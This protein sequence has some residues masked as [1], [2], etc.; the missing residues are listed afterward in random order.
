MR[1]SASTRVAASMRWPA[2]QRARLMHSWSTIVPAP[3]CITVE[4]NARGCADCIHVRTSSN[5]L[6]PQLNC[7]RW[8]VVHMCLEARAA[9]HQ[10]AHAQ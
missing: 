3:L 1:A 6:L 10:R 9:M 8:R 2:Q 4:R 5:S 7:P